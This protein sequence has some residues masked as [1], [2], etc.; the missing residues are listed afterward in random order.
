MPSY[1]ASIRW[2]SYGIPHIFANDWGSAGYGL[3]WAVAEDAIC[4][5]ADDFITVRG[6]R[7]HYFGS[8]KQNIESDAFHKGLLGGELRSNRTRPT[9]QTRPGST[10]GANG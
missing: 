7:S 2:T 6:E 8:T 3:A 1:N 4:V 5:L 9:M 10:P